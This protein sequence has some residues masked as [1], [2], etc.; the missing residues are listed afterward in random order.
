MIIIIN[1]LI[2]KYTQKTDPKVIQ[3]V[4]LI[5]QRVSVILRKA[6]LKIL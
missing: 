2:P 1:H 4:K 6:D 5:N 3:L